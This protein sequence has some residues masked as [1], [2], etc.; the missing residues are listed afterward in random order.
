MIPSVHCFYIKTK[1][2]A[3]FRI[4]I[5]VILSIV[6]CNYCFPVSK[7]RGC[8]CAEKMFH[9]KT[10]TSF[11]SLCKHDILLNN[12]K[13]TLDRIHDTF[14]DLSISFFNSNKVV[15]HA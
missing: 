8:C 13:F 10:L 9:T 7:A 6:L 14:I 1:V 11:A 5:S 15:N 3:D 2:L 12:V 4:S